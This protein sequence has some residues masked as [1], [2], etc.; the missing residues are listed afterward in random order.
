MTQPIETI[1]PHCGKKLPNPEKLGIHLSRDC[2][3][4][5]NAIRDD[6]AVERSQGSSTP[7]LPR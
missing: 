2:P 1:C 7:I 3:V 5:S 4:F 6:V